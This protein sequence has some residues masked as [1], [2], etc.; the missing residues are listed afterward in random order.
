MTK[1]IIKKVEVKKQPIKKEVAKKELPKKGVKAGTKRGSYKKKNKTDLV[2]HNEFLKGV[3]ET[4]ENK[5]D[6]TEIET[7]NK[8]ETE[9]EIKTETETK[10]ETEN[11][12]Q[13]EGFINENKTDEEFK[14]V[15]MDELNTENNAI[16]KT[17]I[18]K[19]QFS[20]LVNGYM[21][22]TLVDFI[23]PFFILKVLKVVNKSEKARSIKMADIKL[24]SDQKLA[25]KESADIIAKM[26][27]DKLS[28]ETVFFFGLGIF[29]FDNVNNQM[30]EK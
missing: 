19:A 22:L 2:T 6:L 15:S 25:L 8:T 17:N 14:E 7:E 11:N 16:Q 21:L 4:I 23:F 1:K 10:T 28:P 12:E 24:T 30:S 26:V 27:F 20:H 13:F 3:N 5:I 9:T 29:Y 18:D